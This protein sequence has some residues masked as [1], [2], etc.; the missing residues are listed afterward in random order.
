MG[1][2]PSKPRLKTPYNLWGP[3]H[4]AITD[5]VF[6]ARVK[7]GDVPASQ[8]LALRSSVYKELFE[9][10]PVA[11]QEEWTD[12]AEEEHQNALAEHKKA[13]AGPPSTKPEDR[14]RY[15]PTLCGIC[16]MLT[17]ST[18]SHNCSAEAYRTYS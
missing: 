15:V 9:E 11:E 18:Q 5:P 3:Q 1:K 6:H 10:L 16:L 8:Q 13:M 7:E 2:T 14:Q 12:R 17:I 4:R